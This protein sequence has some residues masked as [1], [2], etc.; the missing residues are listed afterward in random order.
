M[1]DLK[2]ALDAYVIRKSRAFAEY[3]IQ[4]ELIAN[5]TTAEEIEESVWL[6]EIQKIKDENKPKT[7]KEV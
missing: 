4:K 6:D 3:Q 7:D 1:E 5:A 2:G